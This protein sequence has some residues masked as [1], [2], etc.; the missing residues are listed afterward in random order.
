MRLPPPPPFPRSTS[1]TCRCERGTSL[2]FP[3]RSIAMPAFLFAASLP[4][5][6]GSLKYRRSSYRVRGRK[7]KMSHATWCGHRIDPNNVHYWQAL[8]SA[9][10]GMLPRPEILCLLTRRAPK[11]KINH[12]SA[13]MYTA[14]VVHAKLVQTHDMNTSTVQCQVDAGLS[15]LVHTLLLVPHGSR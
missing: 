3:T 10:H 13:C 2:L 5:C 14:A 9:Q 1:D 15:E 6:S 12:G 8:S 7:T 11:T 4:R